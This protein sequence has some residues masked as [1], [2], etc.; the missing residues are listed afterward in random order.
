MKVSSSGSYVQPILIPLRMQ[1]LQGCGN[2]PRPGSQVAGPGEGGALHCAPGRGPGHLLPRVFPDDVKC[3]A[4]QRT[5]EYSHPGNGERGLGVL[6]GAGGRGEGLARVGAGKGGCLCDCGLGV[7]AFP[8][9]SR[10]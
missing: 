4:S 3:S 9:Q 2:G 7:F 6:R 10:L 5:S 8:V 1:H